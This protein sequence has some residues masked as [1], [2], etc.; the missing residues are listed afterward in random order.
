MSTTSILTTIQDIFGNNIYQIPDYQRGYAWENEQVNDLLNDLENI[1]NSK[2]HYT[3]TMVIIRKDEKRQAGEKFTIYEVIDG[4]QRLTTISILLFCIYEELKSLNK[5]ILPIEMINEYG[6]PEKIA[7]NIFQKYITTDNLHRIILNDDSRDYYLNII[8]KDNKS[9]GIDK[10]ENTSQLNLKCVKETIRQYLLQRRRFYNIPSYFAYLNKLKSKITDSL[11]VNKYEVESNAE[12]G[13]IFEVMN[14]RG[15]SLSQAD[16]IKNYLIYLAYKTENSELAKKI[17]I[18]WGIIFKN[19]MASR[20]SNEDEFLR[21]HW[22]IYSSEYKEYDIHRRVKDNICLKDEGGNK[23]S[24]DE[25]EDK[26]KDYIESLKEASDIFLELN[27]PDNETSFSDDTYNKYELITGIKDNISKFHR[28]RN[29]VSFYPLFI[30]ARRAFKDK[31]DYFLTILNLAEIFTFR[32][33]IIENRRSNTKQTT[34]FRLAFDLYKQ[35][36]KADVDK[37]IKFVEIKNE[38]IEAI[39]TYSSDEDFESN[40]RRINFYLDMQQ[41]EIKYFFYELERQKAKE[42]KEDFGIS[43]EDIEEKTQIEH[44]WSQTP[45]GYDTWNTEQKNIHSNYVH[46]LGNLTITGW[47]PILSNKDFWNSE[48]FTGKRPIYKNS[49]LRVQRELSEYNIWDNNMIKE[50]EEKLIAFSLNRW[51]SDL[52]L[53]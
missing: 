32:V 6:E 20:K 52:L 24:E 14:D 43:W 21:Y 33:Y 5:N 31:P 9:C 7:D 16:K 40:L 44:I 34:F 27:Q 8:I 11:V 38:L 26:I 47:N 23:I 42:V 49:N 29:I 48:D 22:I 28:L 25:I 12:A 3:G 35:K 36:D 4:Q 17:N 41:H 18:Y 39:K 45:K 37:S 50:R 46:K 1:E 2:T 51:G 13:V 30:S 53:S 15:R 10:P 19:L